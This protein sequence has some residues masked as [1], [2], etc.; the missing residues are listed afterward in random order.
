MYCRSLIV[1]CVV[2]MSV[3]VETARE[4]PGLARAARIIG[5]TTANEGEWPWLVNLRGKIVTRT[6]FFGLIPTAHK[7]LFC[8]GSVISDRWIL[9][10]AHCFDDRQVKKKTHIY[11]RNWEA[12]MASVNLRDGIVDRLRHL[13]GTIFNRRDWRT[14]EIDVERIV[15]H[16][17]YSGRNGWSHDIALVKLKRSVPSGQDFSRIRRVKLP[18]T[19]D[20][21]F[22]AI[23][24]TCKMKGWGCTSGGGSIAESARS[25]D[26]PIFSPRRCRNIF[27]ATGMANRICAGYMYSGRGICAGDSGGPLTC[28]NDIGEWVQVG[29]ASFASRDTPGRYPAVF[30]RVSSYL[31]WIKRVTGL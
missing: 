19:N 18:A 2:C 14:W 25:V 28:Q 10:A 26:L 12:K 22:P 5:G 21:S 29:V 3:F 27:A 8:G 13:A 16:P 24:S 4:E 6:T 9:T 31:E 23:G 30:T 1:L 20:T 11:S 15:I 7:H 17:G